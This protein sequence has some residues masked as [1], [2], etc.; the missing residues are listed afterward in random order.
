MANLWIVT[1]ISL[2]WRASRLVAA[3]PHLA[4]HVML[5]EQRGEGCGLYQAPLGPC[6]PQR[7]HYPNIRDFHCYQTSEK[8]KTV[9]SPE[10]MEDPFLGFETELHWLSV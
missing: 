6:R 10:R 8:V 7:H 3:A 9:S 4:L 1:A 2:A 5:E